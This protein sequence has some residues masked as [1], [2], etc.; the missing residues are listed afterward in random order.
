MS[1]GALHRSV[2]EVLDSLAIQVAHGASWRWRHGS[3]QG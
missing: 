1:M 3:V 2:G